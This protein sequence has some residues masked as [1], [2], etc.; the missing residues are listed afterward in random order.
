MKNRKVFQGS[1]KPLTTADGLTPSG[2]LVQAVNAEHLDEKMPIVFSLE[3]P[4]DLS[5]D[6]DK[7]IAS[8]VVLKPEEI[9]EKYKAD[10]KHLNTLTNWL[11]KQGFEITKISG[12]GTSVYTKAKVSQIQK[13]L[14]VNMVRVTKE[15]LGYTAAQNAP[16][17]PENIG[18]GVHAIIGLQPFRQVRK[19]LR[20]RIPKHA[21]RVPIEA[22]NIVGA[23]PSPQIQNAPPYL[24]SE[25]L[26]AYNA[27][28]TGLTGQGQT[29]AI[30]IDTFPDDNDL[31]QFWAN[32]NLPT[33]LAQIEKIN[34][35][36]TALPMPE[37]E[38]TL[39]AEWTSG[40][41]PGANIR[42]YASGSLQYTDLD[43]ALDQIF[44]DLST[45]PGMRQLSISLGLGEIY[46]G[47]PDGEVATQHQ[48]FQKLLAAGVNIFVSTG[49]AGS[50]PDSSGHQP[51]GQLQA[52]H[53]STDPYVVAVGGT[54]LQLSVEGSVSSETG[55]SSG[56]GGISIFFPRPDWQQGAGVP[57]GTMRLVPDVSATAD[58]DF[59]AY[60]YFQ[61][62]VTQIGG[63]SWS[64][65]IW[66]GFCALINQSRA[67]SEKELL[68]S[69]NPQIYRLMGGSCFRDILS[70][71]NGAYQAGSG[72]DLV[73]GLGVPD[74]QQLVQ[75]LG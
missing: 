71:S 53:P 68:S 70:G 1:V 32:N 44:D 50:N 22:T 48:K 73:T 31:T 69:L 11:R 24:A 15:G 66:A 67:N 14:Q 57:S 9:N 19:H 34:V 23:S 55:W 29:I 12:N 21:N 54:T 27:D 16:S 5:A 52:E 59:G 26:K 60:L 40:I 36:G 8:G 39:D 10:T 56:G 33:T 25:V 35:N 49:D 6:L 37:G 65:P 75:A 43:L 20:M 74:L 42:I 2:L 3:L 41:A 13:S 46:L 58:P 72:Y 51:T 64:A 61:G 30:L 63:T 4:A 7:K 45:Q 38:E 18:A 17:L 28:G 47:S 62:S